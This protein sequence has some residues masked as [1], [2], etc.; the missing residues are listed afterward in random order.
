MSR[1]AFT[2]IELLVV[3]AI[4][5]ILAAILFPV[6]AQAK[7]A[8]KKTSDLSNL[9]QIGTATYIYLNDYDD[10]FYAHRYNCGGTVANNYTAVSVCPDYLGNQANGLNSTAPD[11]AG[12]LTSPV[13]MREYYVYLLA[14]YIKS[15]PMWNGPGTTNPFYPGSTAALQYYAN[16]GAK[17]GD[18][19]GGQNSYGHND[20]W[21]S[22]A[23]NVNGGSA[24]LPAPPNATSIPRVS[25]TILLMDS[26]YYGVG[27]D[28]MNA[29]GLTDCSKFIAGCGDTSA[30]YQQLTALG[31]STF[32]A[33]YWANQGGGTYSQNTTNQGAGY[34][35]PFV[36]DSAQAGGVNNAYLTQDLTRYDGHF[37]VEFDDT[38]A[39]N[40]PYQQTLGNICLWSTD[41]EGAHPN[42]N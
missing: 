8:A 32:Y 25:S 7:L 27:P 16:G 21:M 33:N 42:C 23:A 9:Q 40:L 6:F 26:G 17:T 2:L 29:T 28:V 19:Y 20:G 35:T 24:N 5:A 39:K 1:K 4:I 31:T 41:V 18:N 38:H 22:P 37:N 12:G 36:L 30:E 10:T 34:A 15:Y 14:P 13:N 3:I 11:Q